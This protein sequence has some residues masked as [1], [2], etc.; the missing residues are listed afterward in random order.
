MKFYSISKISENM[1]ETPEGY[2]ICLGVSIART[3]EQIYGSNEIPIQPGPDG[4]VVVTRDQTE[5]FRPETIASFEGKSVT[6]THPQDFVAP[7]NWSELSKGIAQNVRRG[8]AEQENDLVADLLITDKEAIQLVKNGLR[9][10]S[11]GY[12]ADYIE[13]GIGRG[14][15]KNIVGNHIALVEE[16]RAGSSYA[17]TDHKGKVIMDPKKFMEKLKAV[18]GAKVVDAMME[19]KKEEKDEKEEPKKE[20]EAMKDDDMGMYD[21]VMKAVKD[22]GTMMDKFKPK[23][24]STQPTQSEPAEV[25]ADEDPMESRMKKLEDAVGGLLKMKDAEKEEEGEEA[26]DA[27]EEEMEDA[28]EEE[29]KEKDAAGCLVGDDA[30]RIE[31]L[32][33]GL[34]ARGKDAKVKALKAVYETTDGKAIIETFTGGKAP[35]FGN[36][37]FVDTVFVAASELVKA[38]RNNDLSG[39]RKSE[40]RDSV[41]GKGAKTPEEI[42]KAN[43]AFYSGKK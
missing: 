11:C 40:A 38:K 2:L 6:I 9:E 41:L 42:N 3:G 29:K 18:F 37:M 21:A 19:E 33:P 32:A 30:S 35:D 10:V 15:Q 14:V 34:K 8:K 20:P 25:V 13:T 22:L 5:V 39:T 27:D 17:I 28:D 36:Q 23:D 43:E 31:I 26:E 4:T 16:G 7:E 1:H 12:L 24:A